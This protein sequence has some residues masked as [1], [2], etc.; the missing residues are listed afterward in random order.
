MDAETQAHLFEPFFTTKGPGKGT[1][2]GLAT[3]YGIMTQSGGHITVDS[4]PGHG[5][6]FTI[7]LPR[8]E[9]AVDTIEPESAQ[10]GHYRGA[11]TMVLV[12]DDTE[13]RDMAQEILQQ[14]GYTVLVAANGHEALQY[15]A[16]HDGPIHM[17]LTDVVMPG[18]SGRELADRLA[19]IRPAIHV[20]Y[21][22]GYTDEALSHH[23]VLDPGTALLPKPFTPHGLIQKVR[24][25]LRTGVTRRE[26]A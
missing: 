9:E 2:L 18:M 14:H 22:S 3:V 5:T 17:L 13:V 20:L 7:Y 1:G 25:V 12:E 8:V 19:R 4:V 11:E 6:T 26:P 24:E 23:G 10:K 15:G 16:Q 21:M